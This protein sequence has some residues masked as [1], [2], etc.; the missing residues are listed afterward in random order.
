[1]QRLDGI[2]IKP[3]AATIII[4]PNKLKKINKIQTR[5]APDIKSRILS[6]SS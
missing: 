1:M 5:R 6:G 3:R 4:Q 2:K